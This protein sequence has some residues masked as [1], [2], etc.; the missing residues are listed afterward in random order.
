MISYNL[1]LDFFYIQNLLY[2]YKITIRG[3]Q[4]I[5]E[6]YQILLNFLIKFD[7]QSIMWLAV[8]L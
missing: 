7:L 2:F 8:I 5:I 4:Q 6:C 3:D 1:Q